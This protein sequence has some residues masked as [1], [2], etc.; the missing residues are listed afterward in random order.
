MS[1]N[2]SRPAMFRSLVGHT[3]VAAIDGRVSALK[4]P[5]RSRP[6]IDNDEEHAAA[7]WLGYYLTLAEAGDEDAAAKAL[8][9]AEELGIL[10]A[11]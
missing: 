1:N 10:V 7:W 2:R 5:R 9:A 4:A 11:A 8:E 6:P 3:L